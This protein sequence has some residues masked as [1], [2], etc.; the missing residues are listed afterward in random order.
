M[1]I[2]LVMS[3]EQN[4]NS[5]NQSNDFAAFQVAF[6][7]V[8]AIRE[9]QMGMSQRTFSRRA[10]ISNSHLRG[11]ENGERNITMQTVIKLAVAFGTTPSELFRETENLLGWK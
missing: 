10:D 7:K 1:V 5:A 8:V 11:I 2:V 3:Q 9:S 4:N 6:G